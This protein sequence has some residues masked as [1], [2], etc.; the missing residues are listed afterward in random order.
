M[1]LRSRQRQ[2]PVMAPA[3]HQMGGGGSPP[4]D[5]PPYSPPPPVM[6]PLAGSAADDDSNGAGNKTAALI[7]GCAAAAAGLALALVAWLLISNRRRQANQDDAELSFKP[8]VC[9]IGDS[10]E[11]SGPMKSLGQ[12]RQKGDRAS[13]CPLLLS[14]IS[15]CISRIGVC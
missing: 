6:V 4:P 5:P 8:V 12:D 2:A 10:S 14:A 9:D 1:L 13:Q 7:A 11:L 15:A 3:P